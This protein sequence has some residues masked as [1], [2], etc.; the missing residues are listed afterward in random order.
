M[1]DL[2]S[3]EMDISACNHLILGKQTRMGVH[4]PSA[5]NAGVNNIS[6]AV[7]SWPQL[8]AS[9]VLDIER[10]EVMVNPRIQFPSNS[11]TAFADLASFSVHPYIFS[12]SHL[13][14]HR[15]PSQQ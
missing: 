8:E 5:T 6:E 13:P 7:K 1:R 3:I 4:H 12:V 11:F 15:R 2:I 14:Y 10:R 9:N